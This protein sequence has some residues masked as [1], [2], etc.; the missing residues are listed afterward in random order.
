MHG[1]DSG[2]PQRGEALKQEPQ[3]SEE[4]A[5]SKSK[6][7]KPSLTSSVNNNSQSGD[8][9]S[10]NPGEE[11]RSAVAAKASGSDLR[12][13]LTTSPVPSFQWGISTREPDPCNCP[14]PTPS[15]GPVPPKGP[16]TGAGGRDPGPSWLP[17]RS[18]P[19]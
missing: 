13:Q 18:G 1:S 19:L 8:I 6:E 3:T 9:R 11:R 17:T 12:I 16:F 7:K 5:V 15:P 10:K 4:T 2:L 14:A